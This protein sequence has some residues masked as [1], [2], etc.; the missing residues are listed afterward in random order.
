MILKQF[1]RFIS[2]S[3]SL[4]ILPLSAI[5]TIFTIWSG[6][7]A[8]EKNYIKREA[9]SEA[10]NWATFVASEAS[11]IK[12]E[13]KQ[14]KISKQTQKLLRFASG[15]GGV[16]RYKFFNHDGVIVY[17]SRQKDIG[18]KSTKSY[19]RE[20]VQKGKTYTKLATKDYDFGKKTVVSEAYVPLMEDGKFVGALEIYVDATRKQKRLHQGIGLIFYFL[21]AL[22]TIITIGWLYFIRRDLQNCAKI[23]QGL[24]DNQNVLE[25]EIAASTEQ[26]KLSLN[27]AQK[28]TEDI[29]SFIKV[30]E[31]N[32]LDILQEFSQSSDQLDKTANQLR[33]AANLSNEQSSSAKDI[34]DAAR[35]NTQNITKSTEQ[36]SKSLTEISKQVQEANSLTQE[37]SHQVDETSAD[38]EALLKVSDRIGQIIKLISDIASQTNLLALNATIEAARAGEAGRGFAVVAGEVKR[39]AD[40][41]AKATDE[42]AQQVSETQSVSMKTAKSIKNINQIISELNEISASITHASSEQAQTTK[43]IVTNVQEASKSSEEVSC[44]IIEVSQASTITRRSAEMVLDSAHELSTKSTKLK[45]EI[46]FFISQIRTTK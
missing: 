14:G 11:T 33:D 9:S 25:R 8:F 41:T 6:L 31:K 4:I 43:Y 21:T 37:A 42:I 32:T 20:I 30:F 39:L 2:K 29:E 34:T 28:R 13:I 24:K 45:T 7:I 46:D 10:V 38:V 19:F 15:A 27:D 5:V 1:T 12:K 17:A 18:T 3:K 35:E 23:Q 16:I 44:N 22:I 36:L 40:Q 26:L